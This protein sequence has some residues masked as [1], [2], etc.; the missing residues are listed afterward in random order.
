MAR[1]FPSN[2]TRKLIEQDPNEI[3]GLEVHEC[4]MVND[5]VPWESLNSE[6]KT[7]KLT[8]EEMEKYLNGELK[9]K[10]E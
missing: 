10:F 6:V 7:R 3:K 9:I 1:F 2:F 5:Y 4:R 8:Q